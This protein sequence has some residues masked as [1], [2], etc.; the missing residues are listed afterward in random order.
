MKRMTHL[1]ILTLAVSAFLMPGCS[2]Q[3]AQHATQYSVQESAM[4]SPPMQ[5]YPLRRPKPK[6]RCLPIASS[7]NFSPMFGLMTWVTL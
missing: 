5:Q 2:Q 4:L 7:L 3:P 6:G 1:I